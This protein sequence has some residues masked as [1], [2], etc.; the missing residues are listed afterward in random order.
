MTPRIYQLC[1]EA[2]TFMA[3]ED[4]PIAKRVA[5]AYVLFLIH[6]NTEDL[7][8]EHQHHLAALNRA[9]AD[10]VTEGIGVT[11]LSPTDANS[12]A[13]HVVDL[14]TGVADHYHGNY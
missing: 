9:F 12:L 2:I 7:P 13:R 10:E 5:K 14:F 3:V 6:V 8:T 1:R 4:A 11:D